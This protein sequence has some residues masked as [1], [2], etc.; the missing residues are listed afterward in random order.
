RAWVKI[1]DGCNHFCSYCVIPI[2]R[3]REISRPIET[4]VNEVKRL[5]SHGFSEIVL[6][7]INIGRYG[8][9]W[10]ERDALSRL[11]EVLS[12]VNG[13]KRLRLSS[14]EPFTITDRL[15]DTVVGLPNVC[16]HLH[17]PLQSGNDDVLRAMKRGYNSA[18]F[19]NLIDTIRDREPWFNV[20]TDL[21]VGFPGED[22]V[23]FEDSLSVMREAMF[24]RVHVFPFS[25]RPET[26][27]S[28][29]SGKIDR[30][31]IKRRVSVALD[32]AKGC[33]GAFRRQFLD[34]TLRVIVE[35]IS[36]NEAEGW[37]DNYLRV[38]IQSL[39]DYIGV[40]DAVYVKV[41]ALDGNYLLGY[42]VAKA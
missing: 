13:L 26:P 27:A 22:E 35:R 32:V 33:A 18:F 31:E 11:I 1:Q 23:A 8:F 21:I 4:V 16:N 34:T 5:V 24:G 2:V 9:D 12:D 39:P 41:K 38:K 7:G 3:G 19:L 17:I 15:I 37:T 20:T 28:G 42:V 36:G 14:I 30:R 29:L 25:E 6:T 40:G 10:H